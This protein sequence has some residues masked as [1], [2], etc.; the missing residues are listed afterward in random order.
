MI[1][2]K[3]NI[4]IPLTTGTQLSIKRW[5]RPWLWIWVDFMPKPTIVIFQVRLCATKAHTFRSVSYDVAV[6]RT[7]CDGSVL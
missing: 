2:S 4:Q 7:V 5:A 3:E 6:R 1:L